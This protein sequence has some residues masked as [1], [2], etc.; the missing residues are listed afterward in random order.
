MTAEYDNFR[1]MFTKF[2]YQ[3]MV[4]AINIF[5]T[6]LKAIDKV[7]L[8]KSGCITEMLLLIMENGSGH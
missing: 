2:G 5:Q 6:N 4:N 3:D 7:S 8:V 1:T